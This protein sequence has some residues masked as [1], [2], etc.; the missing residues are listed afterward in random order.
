MHRVGA[1]ALSPVEHKLEWFGWVRLVPG[2]WIFLCTAKW[3]DSEQGWRKGKD[4]SCRGAAGQ[5]RG[6]LAELGDENVGWHSKGV[7]GQG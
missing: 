1:E 2:G 7:A 6:A 3:S 4:W 5:G